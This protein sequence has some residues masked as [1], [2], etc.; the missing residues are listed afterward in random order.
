ML[1]G[2]VLNLMFNVVRAVLFWGFAFY[3]GNKSL[4]LGS[5]LMV[6]EVVT[7]RDAYL[8]FSLSWF[9]LFS[10]GTFQYCCGWVEGYCFFSFRLCLLWMLMFVFGSLFGDFFFRFSRVLL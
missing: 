1:D 10:W 4:G 3:E 5:L 7:L 6:V 9:R 2:S 8:L